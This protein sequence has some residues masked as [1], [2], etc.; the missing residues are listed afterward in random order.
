MTNIKLDDFDETDGLQFCII[1]D[2]DFICGGCK[3]CTGCVLTCGKYEHR[4]PMSFIFNDCD[5]FEH[6]D[7]E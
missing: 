6:K 1:T 2:D 5:E 4:K 7:N 3:H